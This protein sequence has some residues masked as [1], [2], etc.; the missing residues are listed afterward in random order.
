M[1]YNIMT[2]V[3]LTAFLLS[4]HCFAAGEVDLAEVIEQTNNTW[5]DL[6][7]L[8][9]RA[10]KVG[11]VVQVV[12]AANG[13]AKTIWVGTKGSGKEGLPDLLIFSRKDV[14]LKRDHVR[15]NMDDASAGS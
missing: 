15:I 1:K 3:G 5:L 6:P 2:S 8:T 9:N 12:V 10:V 14:L 4:S 13:S 7:V 11:K